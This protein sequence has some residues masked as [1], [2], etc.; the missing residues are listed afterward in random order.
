MQNSIDPDDSNLRGDDRNKKSKEEFK[1]GEPKCSKLYH[2]YTA[3]YNHCKKAHN[4]Q[5]PQ[6]SLL[7]N[8]P[9]DGP[10][11]EQRTSKNEKE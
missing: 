4:G 10:T 11:K 8:E 3:F 9:F 6:G 5:F 1:C 2:S 7:N